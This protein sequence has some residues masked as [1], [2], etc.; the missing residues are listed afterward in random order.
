MGCQRG[1]GIRESEA[2]GQKDIRSFL[3][4]FLAVEG[5]SEQDVTNPGLGRAENH[6][7]GIPAAAGNMPASAGNPL[8]Q[9]L[10]LCGII[11]LHPRIFHTAFEIEH[12][13]GILTEEGEILHHRV[14]NV[15]T[16]R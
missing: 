16:N 8:F 5:L 11:L 13:V 15:L 4:E 10:I 1:H 7:V 2:V 12:I 6:L 3:A 9:F 14:P